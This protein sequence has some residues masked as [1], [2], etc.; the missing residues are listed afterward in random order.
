VQAEVF[1]DTVYAVALAATSDLLHEQAVR[2]SEQLEK[3][4]T[5][6][7]TT[8]AILLEIGNALSKNRY[9]TAAIEILSSLESDPSVEIIPLSAERYSKAFNLYKSR[10]D[11]EWGLIDCLSFFVMEER[12]IREALTSDEHFEQAGYNTLLGQP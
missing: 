12:G 8:Q 2:L 3:A 10:P 7:I 6:L 5:R 4:G 9:R 1:L 11:K